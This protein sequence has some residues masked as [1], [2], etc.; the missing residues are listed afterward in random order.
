MFR[1][2]QHLQQR[3]GNEHGAQCV[4]A[5]A[6]R[7]SQTDTSTSA[8]SDAVQAIQFHCCAPRSRTHRM[9]PSTSAA[10]GMPK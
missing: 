4:G 1:C 3:G 9:M 10:S 5:A 2:G 8:A 7:T 6:P